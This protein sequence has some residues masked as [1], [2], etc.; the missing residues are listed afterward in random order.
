MRSS[1][2]VSGEY[3]SSFADHL[4]KANIMAIKIP[5]AKF[6]DLVGLRVGAVIH[7]RP[8]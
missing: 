2:P 7:L 3:Y 1:K 5:D 8:L 4:L 6:P